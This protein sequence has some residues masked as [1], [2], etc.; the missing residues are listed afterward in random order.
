MDGIGA[1][2]TIDE[3]VGEYG[4]N[5]KSQR[6]GAWFC[7]IIAGLFL[8]LG[9]AV[10]CTGQTSQPSVIGVVTCL[11]LGGLF[12]LGWAENRASRLIVATDRITSKSLLGIKSIS[13]EDI[14]GYRLIRS[15]NSIVRITR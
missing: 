3:V 2:L 7:G 14:R 8:I 13:L 1:P 12:L 10:V 11:L 9:I 4:P 15:S 5:P 6:L